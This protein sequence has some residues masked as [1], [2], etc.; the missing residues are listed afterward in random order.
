MT[1]PLRRFT[2]INVHIILGLWLL[3]SG[4]PSVTLAEGFFPG[5]PPEWP[6]E[7]PSLYSQPVHS[8]KTALNGLYLP[9]VRLRQAQYPVNTQDRQAS[10]DFYLSQYLTSEGVAP[11]WTGSQASCTPG[12][13]SLE[14]QAAVLRRVN[15]F[16]AM[17]GL[18]TLVTFSAESNRLA[19]AAALM[20]SANRDLSHNP[21]A[22]WKCYSNDGKLG[23][24]SSNLFLGVFGPEA[25]NGYMRDPGEGNNPVGHRRW[26]LYPQTREMG[27]GD[28]P[29]TQGYP[30]AN[31]LRVFDS[32]LWE[33]RPA[34]REEFVA[35]PP[36]GYVPF[37]VVFAKWSFAYAGADFSKAAVFVHSD[38]NPV[39]IRQFSPVS[40]YGENTLV[41]A[42]SSLGDWET[43]PKPSADVAYHVEIRN[44]AIGGQNRDFTYTVI[45]FDPAR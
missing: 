36:P 1:N 38:G 21:P 19:Q 31:A 29:A 39:A 16:R 33:P 18:P 32:H 12:T 43:W 25:I 44:V 23:A 24:G 20:M 27:S 35:W 5:P 42:I 3:L 30:A 14:F 34:T 13:T 15:Y 37:Q 4:F 22:S 45:V 41:W 17:A 10:L 26:I 8:G 6:A 9:L 7:P 28:V 40:G 2:R 11:G